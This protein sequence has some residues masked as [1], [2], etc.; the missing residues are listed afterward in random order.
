MKITN[1]HVL[2]WGGVLSNFY[3]CENPLKI[4]IDGKT[5]QV[6]TSEHAFMIFKAAHFEDWAAVD[7]ISKAKT[8]KEAKSIGRSVKNYDDLEWDGVR[9]DYM[10]KALVAK[11]EASPIFSESLHKWPGKSFVEASPYDKIWG[12]GLEE[13]DPDADDESKWRGQN[14]LGQ[15]LNELRDGLL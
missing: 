6:P 2:F 9:K 3:E 8:P 10:K 4:E 14:L 15:C 7:K 5:I 11:K 13:L 12:I 1:K